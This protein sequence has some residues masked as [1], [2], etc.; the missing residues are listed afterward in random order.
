MQITINTGEI[1]GDEATIREEVIN[2]VS[3][4]LITS[5]RTRA[6]EA[7]DDMLKKNLAD[8]VA[9]TVERVVNATMDTVYTDVDRYGKTGKTASL[10][11]RIADFVQEQCTFKK[12]Q[13]DSKRNPF[14]AVIEKTV[15]EEVRKFKAD[16]NTMVTKQV[17]EQSMEMAR[18]ALLKSMGLKA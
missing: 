18:S 15:T 7:L 2:Q 16:F 17:M 12:E 14:T 6:N 3:N 11:E 4:A 13:Y 5:M 8:V 9:E 1:L 10:R